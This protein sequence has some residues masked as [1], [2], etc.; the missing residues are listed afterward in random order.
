MIKDLTKLWAIFTPAERQKTWWMLL[1]IVLMAI[2]ETLGVISIMPFLTVLGRPGIVQENPWLLAVYERYGFQS[3]RTFTVSLGLASIA[4]VVGSSAF[5]TVT[6]HVLNRF[7]HLQRHAISTRL[8]GLYLAQPYA[9]HLTRNPSLLAKNV[10]SEVDQL[11]FDLLHPLSLL[12]AQGAVVLAVSLLIL[13]YDPRMAILIVLTLACLYG[14]IYQMTRNRLARIGR[15]RREANGR[16]FQSCNEA[17][18]G[19]KDV[20]VTQSAQAYLDKFGQASRLYSRHTATNETLNQSPLYM[21]EAVGYT[22]LITVALVL[23]LRSNDVAHVLPAIG[24]YGFAAYRLLPAVQIIYRG[25]A[26]LRFSSAALEAIHGDLTLPR[27]P[28]IQSRCATI[29]PAREIKLE[30]IRFA[31][32]SSADAPVLNDFHLTIPANTTLGISGR[33]GAGKSTLMDILLGLLEPQQGKLWVDDMLITA[34]NVARWQAS[35]GYVPQHI[36]LADTTVAENIAFGL[37][38]NEIDMAALER[39]ARAAQIHDFISLE[40]PDGYDTKVGDRGI[41]LSGGQRQRIGMARALYRDPPIIFMDEATSALDSETEEALNKAIQALSESKTIVAIAHREKTLSG[42][43]RVISLGAT[44]HASP[45]E[46][47]NFQAVQTEP[48]E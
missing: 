45:R 16:R 3:T 33:S 23:L 35:I 38:R 5:K 1:L 31:Y 19:I 29:R 42:F 4:V 14:A 21:V 34:D 47:T 26:R 41:R 37:P 36:F 20:K 18:G 6:L 8:L 30:G 13:W 40:L 46:P 25:F 48:R 44:G 17:L 28:S 32:S 24:L 15:E 10:L 2:A 11:I 27:A 7:V 39:A 12:L 9:F 43:Q 22:G